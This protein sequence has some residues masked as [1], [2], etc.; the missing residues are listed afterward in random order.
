MKKKILFAN[1]SHILIT[2][3]GGYSKQLYYLFHIFKE[4]G[5]E[6]YYLFCAFKIHSNENHTRLYSYSELKTI[7]EESDFSPDITVLDDEILKEISYFSIQNEEHIVHVNR[8]NEIIDKYKIDTFFFLGDAFLFGYNKINS[9]IIVPSY[10]WYPCH[11]FPLCK[12]D[13]NGMNCFSNLLSLSPSIKYEL[14]KIFPYKQIYYLPHIVEKINISKTKSEIREK[15]NIGMDKKVILI[16]AQLGDGGN[17]NTIMNRKAIDVHLIAFQQLNEKY[18]DTHLFLH[19]LANKYSPDYP[20][21]SLFKHLKLN[22]D[23]FT[24]NKKKLDELDLHELYKMSDIYLCCSKGEG[25]GVP[26][27][28]AQ[29]YDLDVITNNF[30]SMTEHNFQ[31]NTI[32]PSTKERHYNLDSDWIMTSSD[33]LFNKLEEIYLDKNQQKIKKSIWIS[34]HLTEYNNIKQKIYN[35]INNDIFNK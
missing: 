27:L 9:Q 7:Y 3:Y 20:L 6:L 15:W 8:V 14:E 21:E 26:I 30:L 19:T 1:N 5:F 24:W 4:F 10:Y 28:E 29:H 34:Q 35:I 25:F 22:N 31:N 32:M 11:Y 16:I 2:K 13:I 33:N 18:S 23:N 12:L 17:V